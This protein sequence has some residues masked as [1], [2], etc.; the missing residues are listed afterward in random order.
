MKSN[1]PMNPKAFN[2]LIKL[3]NSIQE[4]NPALE[5]YLWKVMTALYCDKTTILHEQDEVTDKA[6][7]IA[8]GFVVIYRFV[9][10]NLEVIRICGKGEIVA[11]SSFML[12]SSSPYYIMAIKG[13]YLLEVTARQMEY[14]YHNIPETESLARKVLASFEAKELERD[15]M[16]RK[17]GEESVLYFYTQFLELF[18]AGALVKDEWVASYLMMTATNLSLIRTRLVKKGLLPG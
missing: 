8:T 9:E 1:A 13:T 7:F 18:P 16:V 15:N 2:K 17:G 6:Y 14:A 5:P 11:G 4:I 3:L 10:G 12:G